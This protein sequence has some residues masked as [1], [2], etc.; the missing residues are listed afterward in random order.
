[1]KI[2][3]WRRRGKNPERNKNARNYNEEEIT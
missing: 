3:G 1:M 2:K